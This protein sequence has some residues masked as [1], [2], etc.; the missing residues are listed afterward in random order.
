[1]RLLVANRADV[2][3]RNNGGSVEYSR[4]LPIVYCWFRDPCA[5]PPAHNCGLYF[6]GDTGVG[7]DRAIAVRHGCVAL[8]LCSVIYWSHAQLHSYVSSGARS[9]PADGAP[10]HHAACARQYGAGRLRRAAPR[11]EAPDKGAFDAAVA[12]RRTDRRAVS[13]ACSVLL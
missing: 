1:M 11:D 9:H 3:A 4:V 6:G 12:V 2:T 5:A 10:R 13:H 7:W 8:Q